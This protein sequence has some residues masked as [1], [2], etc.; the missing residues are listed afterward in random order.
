MVFYTRCKQMLLKQSKTKTE[1]IERNVVFYLHIKY[2]KRGQNIEEEK[3]GRN[4]KKKRKQEKKTIFCLCPPGDA[5][6]LN[7]NNSNSKVISPISNY[8]VT[9][10]GTILFVF[11]LRLFLHLLFRDPSM[12][13]AYFFNIFFYFLSVISVFKRCA[14]YNQLPKYSETLR[15]KINL[16]MAFRQQSA[17]KKLVDCE[18]PGRGCSN[19]GQRYPPDKSLS[20]GEVLRE[21]YCVIRWIEIYPVDSANQRWTIGH[22]FLKSCSCTMPIYLQRI[23]M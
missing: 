4:K 13:K 15:R 12:T 5:I 7:L 17:G 11:R 1:K 23:L 18:L 2:T 14:N 8:L 9:S 6:K 22:R 19:I 20:S 21:T 3:K 10:G 16:F